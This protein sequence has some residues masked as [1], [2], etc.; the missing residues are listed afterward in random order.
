MNTYR[1][2]K[3]TAL[4]LPGRIRRS[5]PLRQSV[6]EV[7]AGFGLFECCAYKWLDYLRAEGASPLANRS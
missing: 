4:S 1:K 5:A 7:A 2:A 3:R 6:A